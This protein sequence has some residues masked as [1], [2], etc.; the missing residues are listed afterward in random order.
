MSD[1]IKRL[2]ELPESQRAMVVE[3]MNRYDPGGQPGILFVADQNI[4]DRVTRA[5]PSPVRM[6]RYTHHEKALRRI[7]ELESELRRVQELSLRELGVGLVDV[8]VFSGSEP[9]AKE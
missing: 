1:L 5:N 6:V 4:H 8:R 7:A 3:L 9:E 2:A